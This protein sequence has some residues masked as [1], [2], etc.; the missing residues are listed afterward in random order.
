MNCRP[1]KVPGLLVDP[2]GVCDL[3]PSQALALADQLR[4]AAEFDQQ[5]RAACAQLRAARAALNAK[6][7]EVRA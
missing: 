1:C 5:M 7:R 2:G 4:A 3:T 6:A